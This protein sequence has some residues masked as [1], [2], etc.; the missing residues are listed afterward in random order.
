MELLNDL[1]KNLQKNNVS[2]ETLMGSY[3]SIILL[4]NPITPHICQ[5][6]SDVLNLKKFYKK[7]SWP[8]VDKN[9]LESDTA[10]IIVQINGK[11]RKKIEV[12]IDTPQAEIEKIATDL[13]VIKKYIENKKIK[14]I[15]Y[16]K[17]KLV[18]IVV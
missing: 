5:E 17:N 12:D 11:V 9:F 18:N 15:I 6:I 4:L 1:N 3:E 14:K 7:V 16:I 13:D 2:K 8:E 10:L